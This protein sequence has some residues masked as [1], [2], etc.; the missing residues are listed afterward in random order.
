[1]NGDELWHAVSTL[2]SDF[3]KTHFF[4]QL[5]SASLRPLVGFGIPDRAF[6]EIRTI[7]RLK[8]RISASDRSAIARSF[9]SLMRGDIVSANLL[10]Q[11]VKQTSSYAGLR[12]IWPP[13]P[14]LLFQEL[15]CDNRRRPLTADPAGEVTHSQRFFFP[16][17][18]QVAPL[19]SLS[20]RALRRSGP[21]RLPNSRPIA[22]RDSRRCVPAGRGRRQQER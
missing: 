9:T 4:G 21:S 2:C 22:G 11:G 5:L 10:P 12:P 1:M 3:L 20:P 14:I 19:N 16:K 13:S 8:V 7:K 6:A 18:A 15:D 17:L